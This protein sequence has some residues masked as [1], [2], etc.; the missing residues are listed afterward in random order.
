LIPIIMY[1]YEICNRKNKSQ[2]GIFNVTYHSVEMI[3]KD[4]PCFAV[5]VVNAE[6]GVAPLT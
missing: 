6:R 3:L 5:F 2:N 4:I 1:L